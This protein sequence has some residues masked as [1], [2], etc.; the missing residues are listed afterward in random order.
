MFMFQMPPQGGFVPVGSPFLARFVDPGRT[1]EKIDQVVD[2]WKERCL[3]E[4]GSL[5]FESRGVWTLA[6]LREFLDR[7][8]T[9]AIEGTGQDFEEKLA[10]QLDDA[11]AD[12]RW[13]AAELL[14]VHFLFAYDSIGP[15][16]KIE[17]IRHAAGTAWEE[18]PPGWAAAEEAMHEGIGNPGLGYNVRRD[19]Q[20]SYLTDFTIR[21]KELAPEERL[22][23]LDDPW[24]LEDFA[25]DVS[26][27]VPRR[28]MRHILLH[29]LRPDEFER[30]SSGTHK[31]H[32]AEAFAEEFLGGD[33]APEDLDRRLLR[34]REGLAE[35]GARQPDLQPGE[36]DHYYSP[37]HGVW[38][39]G[40]ETGEG[41][42]DLELLTYKKQLVFYGPP[43]TSKTYRTRALA[44]T[45]IRRE[46]LKR[47][48]VKAF[49]E[50]QDELTQ[51]TGESIEWVQLHPGY[52]YE[53]FIR[54]LRLQGERTVYAPGLLLRLVDRMAERSADDA[55]P[56]VLVLD[57]INRSDL[58]RMFG[59]AFSLLENRGTT[60][61]LPGVDV[62]ADPV[63]L[64]LPQDLYVIGTMNLIDQSVEQLDF[65]L[66]RRFFWRSCGFQREAIIAVNR[67]RWA[68]S[69]GKKYGWD[70]GAEDIER[71]ADR[72]E[73]LNRQIAA[74]N[75]LGP[76]YALGHTYYFD[77]A[78]FIGKFLEGIKRLQGGVLWTASGKP[79]Q[80]LNDLWSLSL[81]PVLR[82]YLEGID[83]VSASEEIARLRATLLGTGGS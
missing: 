63:E 57:E 78:F 42:G 3:L 22:A 53:E 65:A 33:D 45:L 50:R 30:I 5:L 18:E 29:L 10:I 16:K 31:R 46:A 20:L 56:V 40:S 11:S 44:E 69:V 43:G 70:R 47:W 62:D 51:R 9:G 7:F 6:N 23:K 21:F 41:T 80:A 55:L 35:A 61:V 66:R 32:I 77:A 12:I 28:E 1:R 71:L 67:E 72:A 79:R 52:G 36:I 81:E 4:D 38:D 48:G 49:F 37:L 26:D 8:L 64:R 82:Q 14:L 34:I 59:E 68:G 24:A 25:D 58:S 75:H 15:G 83:P 73:Q 19:Y 74:S 27:N 39:P 76:Q 60:V 54:G 13:L 2:L 17:I